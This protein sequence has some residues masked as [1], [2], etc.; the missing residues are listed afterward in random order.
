MDAKQHGHLTHA[1]DYTQKAIDR[2]NQFDGELS[3]IQRA[4]HALGLT[5]VVEKVSSARLQNSETHTNLR[6]VLNHLQSI[7]QIEAEGEE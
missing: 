3:P 2:T 5:G 4:A 7:E 1:L 6:I